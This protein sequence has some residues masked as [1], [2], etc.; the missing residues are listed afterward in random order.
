MAAAVLITTHPPWRFDE[1]L[2]D[3]KEEKEQERERGGARGKE[4]KA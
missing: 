2:A 3:A 1:L 4:G